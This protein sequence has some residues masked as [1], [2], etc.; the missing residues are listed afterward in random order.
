MGDIVDYCGIVERVEGNRVYVKVVQQPACAGCRAQSACMAT[1]GSAPL[2][3]VTAPPGAFRPNESV[4][5]EGSRSMGLQAVLSAFV[6]P[7]LLVTGAVIAGT[8]V[9][10]DEGVSA[11]AGLFLLFPYYVILYFLRPVLKK[12]FVFSIKKI[13]PSII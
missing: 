3:E 5:L 2:I 12:R 6:V 7:L 13:N 11:L 1:G 9:G 10:W 4:R 8:V